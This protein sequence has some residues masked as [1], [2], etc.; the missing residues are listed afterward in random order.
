MVPSNDLRGLHLFLGDYTFI[1]ARPIIDDGP[2]QRKVAFSAP[3]DHTYS[4]SWSGISI[5]G[6]SELD[7]CHLLIAQRLRCVLNE[8]AGDE[9]DHAVAAR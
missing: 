1:G 5:R 3:A 9:L 6:R 4:A 2:N 7:A 8:I